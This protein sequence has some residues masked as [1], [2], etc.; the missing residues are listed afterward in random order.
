MAEH[1]KE[2]QEQQATLTTQAVQAPRQAPR[3][4]PR[5]EETD[6]D[7]PQGGWWLWLLGLG[8]GLAAISVLVPDALRAPLAFAGAA[9]LA[10]SIGLLILGGQ[11]RGGGD[12]R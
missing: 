1:Q 11:R 5:D 9:L 3:Q 10:V 2:R 7:P 6:P 12:H 4:E 8:L